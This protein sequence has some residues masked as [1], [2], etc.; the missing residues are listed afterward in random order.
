MERPERRH[1]DSPALAVHP[2]SQEMTMSTITMQ[3]RSLLPRALACLRRP[4]AAA[5]CTLILGSSVWAAAPSPVGYWK[6]VNYDFETGQ[7]I[8]TVLRCMKADGSL[9][10]AGLWD[11][12][13]EANGNQVQL[14]AERIDGSAYYADAATFFGPTTLAGSEQSW[15]QADLTAGYYI[16]NVWTLKSAAC[17]D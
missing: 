17:P 12:R 7:V 4:A 11:G 3:S 5:I 13:W 16:A 9:T 1:D 8:N 14:R 6:V 2:L 15:Q 10:E